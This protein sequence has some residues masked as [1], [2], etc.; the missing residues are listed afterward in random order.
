M[1]QCETKTV[2]TPLCALLDLWCEAYLT[3]QWRWAGPHMFIMSI[4]TTETPANGHIDDV[5]IQCLHLITNY[6]ND[7]KKISIP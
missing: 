5:Q 7:Q 6:T 2:C 3:A 1:G 4:F